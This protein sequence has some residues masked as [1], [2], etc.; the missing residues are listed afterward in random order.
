MVNSVC[1]TL[2][3]KPNY[4]RYQ[5]L[6]NMPVTIKQIFRKRKPAV[7]FVSEKLDAETERKKVH[8]PLNA[9]KR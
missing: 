5:E 3:T 1:P 2:L 4:I 9:R 8:W 7:A 6:W